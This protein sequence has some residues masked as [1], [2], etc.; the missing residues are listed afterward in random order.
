MSLKNIARTLSNPQ[1]EAAD[2]I[3][4]EQSKLTHLLR[5]SLC[6]NSGT[7]VVACARQGQTKESIETMDLCEL[8]Q[9]S[10]TF[11][12]PPRGGIWE[13]NCG[14]WQLAITD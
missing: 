1:G 13:Q 2:F 6:A 10:E 12:V 14:L 5:D 11:P 8:L 9:R 7:M 3:N 4:F